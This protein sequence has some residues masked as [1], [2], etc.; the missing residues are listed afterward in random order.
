MK[1]VNRLRSWS[2]YPQI[3]LV[4]VVALVIPLFLPELTFY[5][6]LLLSAVVVVGLSLFMGYAG[7]A[8]LGQGAFVAVGA[9]TVGVFTVQWHLPPLLALVCAPIFA[10]LVAAL[11]GWPLLRL[12][13]HYLAFGTLAILLLVQALMGVVPLF[14]RGIGISGIPPLFV[15]PI[16]NVQTRNSTLKLIY[17][18]LA[19]VLLVIALVLSHRV[20]KSR[21]GRGIRALAGSESAAAS[22]GVAVLGSKLRVFVLA[23]VFAGL[24]GA[25]TAFYFPF[26]NP[27]S[28]PPDQSFEYVIMAVVGGVGTL[29]GGLTGAILVAV[30]LK[31]LNLVSNLPDMP[32]VLGPTLQYGG[33]GLVLVLVLVFM[34]NGL[35]PTIT[36]A[37]ARVTARR[38][39][40]AKAAAPTG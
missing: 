22:A 33:Y 40:R 18:T 1:I 4:A 11:I 5:M 29:W 28:F 31:L 26:I 25:L 10:A 39:A 9:L 3:A 13:G 17:V 27:E 37:R 36:D 34:P 23:A 32:A 19:V 30:L 7:Q 35:V 12:R 16:D 6:Q 38:A 20:V 2:P 14:G 8:A 21:F 15:L 24:V